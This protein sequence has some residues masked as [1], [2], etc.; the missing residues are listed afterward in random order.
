[1]PSLCPLDL[2]GGRSPV[3]GRGGGGCAVL[4]SE[5]EAQISESGASIAQLKLDLEQAKLERRH[6][7]EYDMIAKKILCAASCTPP[8]TQRARALPP[9]LSLVASARVVAPLSRFFCALVAG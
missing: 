4:C 7:E 2:G 3:R 1:V 9:P 5:V 6:R 8:P